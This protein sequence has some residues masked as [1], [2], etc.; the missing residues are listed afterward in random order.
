[1]FMPDGSNQFNSRSHKEKKKDS[2]APAIKRNAFQTTTCAARARYE[3]VNPM[4]RWPLRRDAKAKTVQAYGKPLQQSMRGH[5]STPKRRLSPQ[6]QR[7]HS[8]RDS[9]EPVFHEAPK[10]KLQRLTA[11]E[12]DSA[13]I[14][15]SAQWHAN[16]WLATSRWASR[17]SWMNAIKDSIT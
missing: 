2:Q 16:Y 12:P 3:L 15:A 6:A 4:L 10:E 13:M 5:I 17:A 14:C 11:V 1:M 8:S 9:M 7:T